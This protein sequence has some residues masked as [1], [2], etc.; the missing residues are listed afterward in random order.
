MASSISRSDPGEVGLSLAELE[1]LAKALDRNLVN[2]PLSCST[3]AVAGLGHTV[4]RLGPLRGLE[5]AAARPVIAAVLAERRRTKVCKPSLV[6]T[7]PEAISAVARDTATV[8]RELFTHAEHSVL[9]AGYSFDHGN[10]IL[11]PL[12]SSMQAHD[13]DV[14]LFV[15]IPR[16]SYGD[17]VH[18][19]VTNWVRDFYFH[20]WKFSMHPTLY[21][22]P[23]TVASKAEASLHAKCIVVDEKLTLI[24]SANFTNRG[25]TRNVEVGVL[26]DDSEFARTLTAQWFQ[27]VA[28]GVFQAVG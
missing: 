8:V 23:R 7:G 20:V 9:V 1:S 22:D 21:F 14:S 6:W 13:L 17:D 12:Y 5:P 11:S 25:Q 18:N 26:L 28:E 19:H 3:L 10:E 15:E 27:A 4:G 24:T 2:G 16:S